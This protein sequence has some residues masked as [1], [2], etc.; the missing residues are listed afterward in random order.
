[1]KF[2]VTS[3][4]QRPLVQPEV[5]VAE[6]RE[7]RGENAREPGRLLLE[8]DERASRR[9]RCRRR[10]RKRLSVGRGS[11]VAVVIHFVLLSA[12]FRL[13]RSLSSCLS[14]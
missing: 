4:M 2:T 5:Q 11:L 8:N 3:Q 6:P 7:D 14:L 12:A 10:R 1:M 9:R 13:A